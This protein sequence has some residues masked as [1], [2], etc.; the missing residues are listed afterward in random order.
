MSTLEVHFQ[1]IKEDLVFVIAMI[2][3]RNTLAYMTFASNPKIFF[4]D[5]SFPHIRE[6]VLHFALKLRG[7]YVVAC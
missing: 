6:F 7:A 3:H 1:E 5:L 2:Q 4:D